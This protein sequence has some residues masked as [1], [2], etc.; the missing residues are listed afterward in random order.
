MFIGI[1]L[2]TSSIKAVLIDEQQNCIS[3]TNIALT[4]QRPHPN[5]SEQ[6][7]EQWWQS[8]L[9]VLQLLQTKSPTAFSATR[10]IG[11]SGQMHGAVLLDQHHQVLRPAILWNDGRAAQQC[12]TLLQRAPEAVNITGNLIMPGFTAP[13]L[14]W[15]VEHE[16]DIFKRI[17]KILLPKD[18]LRFKLTGEFA[19]DLSDASGTAWLDVK[20]RCW[21]EPM[22]TASG[23]TIDQLPKLFEGNQITGKLNASLQKQFGFKHPVMIAAGGGDNAA[24][25]IG[26]G[27]TY[28]GY[29]FV[30]LGTSGVYFVADDHYHARPQQAIHTMCHALPKLWHVM[31]V[32]LSAASAVTW[33]ANLLHIEDLKT[34]AEHTAQRHHLQR[35]LFLPYLSGERTPHNDP[36]A[37]GA[38]IGLSHDTRDTDL[39]QA[40][41]EGV[42]FAF[43]AGQTALLETRIAIEK[44]AI[45]GGGAK[46]QYWSS[47]MASMLN[48]PL[49]RYQYSELGGA[50]G[51][52]LLAKLAYQPEFTLE[53]PQLIAQIDPEPSWQQF[54]AEQL[55]LY[56]QL[57]PQLKPFF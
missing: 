29:G 19:T 55:D 12:H 11:L 18:Y 38:F 57:Y 50:Y 47:I 25:A 3:E 37:R 49:Y 7:P 26:C 17:S 41:F 51:A 10:A 56:R 46:S 33:L 35:L 5:W 6:H 23:C 16:P 31:N 45:V 8:C 21:S 15:V 34:F 42:G 24:S 39:L 43:A 22:I 54:Y 20:N 40:V 1:D 27:A 9:E 36:N 32:H 2:G 14:L 4:V 13:K 30:S 48:R 28:S 52:A 44:I 53:S